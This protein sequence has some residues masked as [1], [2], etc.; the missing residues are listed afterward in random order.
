[1]NAEEFKY[2]WGGEDWDLLDRIINL[3]LEVERIN[4]SVLVCAA[5]EGGLE[6]GGSVERWH[7]VSSLPVSSRISSNF[8]G[9]AGSVLVTVST[10]ITGSLGLCNA[11][12]IWLTRD[13]IGSSTYLPYVYVI[14]GLP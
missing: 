9:V 11:G 14:L 2:K 12:S 1:M 7:N 10:S 5:V 8:S 3:S 13:N 6:G 4:L